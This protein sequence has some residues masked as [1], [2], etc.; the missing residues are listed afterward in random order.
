MN[1]FV[2]LFIQKFHYPFNH[3]FYNEKLIVNKLTQKDLY[4]VS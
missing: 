2:S 4:N 3:F 1:S